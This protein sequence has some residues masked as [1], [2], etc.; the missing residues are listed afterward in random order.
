MH[1]LHATL[2]DAGHEAREISHRSASH[3][4]DAERPDRELRG[5]IHELQ[6]EFRKGSEALELLARP[7]FKTHRKA[8]APAR[9]PRHLPRQNTIIEEHRVLPELRGLGKN[10]AVEDLRGSHLTHE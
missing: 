3:G 10:V 4:H 5:P 9:E 8:P 7:Y 6:D 1:Q 2:E